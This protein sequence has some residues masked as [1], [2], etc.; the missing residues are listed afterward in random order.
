MD[1]RKDSF[2]EVDHGYTEEQARAEAARCLSCGVCSECLSCVDA[3][4]IKAIDLQQAAVTRDI[5]VGAVVMA[6]GYK[7]YDARQS[8]ELGQGRYPNVLSSIQY[9]RQLSASGP[10][11][12]KV[13]RPSDNKPPRRIAWLQCVGSRDADHDY[14][15]SVCCMYATKQATITKGHWPDTDTEIFI[16]DL[17]SFSKGYEAYYNNARENLGIR[18][19]RCRVSRIVEDPKTRNLVVRFLDRKT[20]GGGTHTGA[21]R[22]EIFDMVVLSSGMEM[23]ASTRELADR[24]GVEVDHNGFCSTVQYDPPANQPRGLLR[25]RAVPRAERHSRIPAR[26]QRGRGSGRRHAAQRTRQPDP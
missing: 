13:I 18:Y 8:E 15:S 10:T 9:E 6:P 2:V 12:G 4:D 1:G 17:R 11:R 3:C 21:I 24:L 14:C 7:P 5:S 16:M 22:E 25:G 23:A 19:T 26:S 20:N